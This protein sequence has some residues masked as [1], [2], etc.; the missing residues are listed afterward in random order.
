MTHKEELKESIDH[1]YNGL[2]D[3]FSLIECFH[4]SASYDPKEMSKYSCI[5]D[6]IDAFG[7]VLEFLRS[8]KTTFRDDLIVIHSVFGE[9]IGFIITASQASFKFKKEILDPEPNSITDEEKK[10]IRAF[11]SSSI[12]S[13]KKVHDIVTSGDYYEAL[14][15]IM[16]P[17][18]EEAIR[19]VF[20][21]GSNN[22]QQ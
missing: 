11:A 13:Q 14:K 19:N 20:N 15:E 10:M 22:G 17:K 2:L 12:D 21:N 3:C 9:M 18:F 16:L 1:L 4:F 5:K 7:N 6:I 8:D